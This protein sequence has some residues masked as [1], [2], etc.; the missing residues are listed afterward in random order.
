[1]SD[2]VTGPLPIPRSL[3]ERANSTQS[4]IN[5]LRDDL[6][7]VK[8]ELGEMRERIAHA[9]AT[10][11]AFSRAIDSMRGD[12]LSMRTELNSSIAGLQVGILTTFSRLA[13]ALI[14]VVVI[15]VAS[16][17]AVVGSGIYVKGFGLDIGSNAEQSR[18]Q[19]NLQPASKMP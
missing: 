16:V 3:P 19:Q 12:F 8:Q 13:L 11:T 18:Q 9:E 1:M 10:N 5:G 4:Q 2:P 15:A 7:E 14:V 6:A 17:S